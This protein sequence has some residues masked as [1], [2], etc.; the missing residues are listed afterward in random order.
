MQF[1]FFFDRLLRARAQRPRDGFIIIAVLWIVMM[2]AGLAAA[3]TV[4]VAN[5]ALAVRVND[6]GVETEALVSAGV[7]LAAYQLTASSKDPRPSHGEFDVRLGKGNVA[8]RYDSEAARIDLNVAPKRLLAGLFT[9]LGAPSKD[10]ADYLADQIIGWR[11]P[12]KPN[13]N[14][15]EGRLGQ[16]AEVTG[17][18]SSSTTGP[19]AQ[20]STPFAHVDEL[21]L[22]QGLPPAFVERALSF[23]T[24]YSG[25]SEINI[26]AA[27]PVV[28]AALPDM[29]PE[30]LDAI[31][32]RRAILASNPRSTADVLGFDQAGST[33]EPGDTFRI[34]VRIVFDDGRRSASEVVIF[35]GHDDVPYHVLSW[36][37]D[38]ANA[39]SRTAGVQ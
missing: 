39:W 28:L 18:T 34:D 8:V 27:A 30:R 7:E 33:I 10:D 26:L 21:W 38:V 35:L 17:M 1:Q 32:K 11:K 31:L 6:T 16:T 25:R 20:R 23:V 12:Q 29:T 2:L 19:Y 5:T 14:D 36:Q 37:D 22:V 24:V 15:D 4:Y 13:Q 9:A 3:Y